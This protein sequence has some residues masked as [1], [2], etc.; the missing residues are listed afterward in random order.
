[1]AILRAV[2]AVGGSRWAD[3]ATSLLPHRDRWHIRKRFQVLQRRLPKGRVPM[4]VGYLRRSPPGRAPPTRAGGKTSEEMAAAVTLA[5]QLDQPKKRRRVTPKEKKSPKKAAA[6]T[7]TK[8]K[9]RSAKKTPAKKAP[10]N[11]AGLRGISRPR[12]PTTREVSVAS[13]LVGGFK[14]SHATDTEPSNQSSPTKVGASSQPAGFFQQSRP[15]ALPPLASANASASAAA[16]GGG[17]E[18]AIAVPTPAMAPDGPAAAC[19]QDDEDTK[20]DVERI[21]GQDDW[22]GMDRLIE[23]GAA[24]SRMAPSPR[25]GPAPPRRSPRA[26]A[27]GTPGGAGA[28][29]SVGTPSSRASARRTATFSTPGSSARGGGPPPSSRGSRRPAAAAG[30]SPPKDGLISPLKFCDMPLNEISEHQGCNSLIMAESDFDAVTALNE[31]SNS[32]PSPARLVHVPHHAE[33]TTADGAGRSEV[34]A[35]PGAVAGAG[36]FLAEEGGA[37][38]GGQTVPPGKRRKKS[39]FSEVRSRIVDKSTDGRR[40]KKAKKDSKQSYII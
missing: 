23:S 5:A 2:P 15:T 4:D 16:R 37:E 17:D 13:L 20:M 36:P 14:N 8:A 39:L 40:K 21:L 38:Q 6:G 12:L 35:A 28:P 27:P 31:L 1:V 32:A 9:A 34:A 25:K 24:E 22:S 18:P 11:F 19:R 33:L 7:K 10:S 26:A 29:R 30:R 3:I